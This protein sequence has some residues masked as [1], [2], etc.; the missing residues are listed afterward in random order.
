MIKPK[1]LITLCGL[2]LLASLLLNVVPE[3]QGLLQA[4]KTIVFNGTI[5]AQTT[6]LPWLH[7]SGQNIYDSNGNLVKIKAS[8]I[9][10]GDGSSVTETDIQNIKAMGFN[11]IRWWLYWGGQG[12][13][14]LPLQPTPSSINVNYFTVGQGE[15]S[16]T[17]TDNVITWAQNAG[18]YVILCP[19]WSET[20]PAPSW[21][22]MGSSQD[23]TPLFYNTQVQSGVYYMYNWIAQ[24]Y[25]SYSNVIFESMNEIQ[26]AQPV[27]SAD[28]TAFANFNAG[29]LSAIES[30][31]GANS[32]L[33]IIQMLLDWS[34][35]NYVLTGPFF[36]GTHANVLMATHSYAFVDTQM[37]SYL[38]YFAS[39]WANAIHAQNL[40]W[41]DTE[42]STAENTGGSPSQTVGLQQ[43]MDMFT[44]YNSAG[45]GYFCYN[46]FTNHQGD[47]NIANSAN[48]AQII[49]ILFSATATLDQ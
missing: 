40:P 28:R 33:K 18:L 44:K 26:K 36:S 24:R 7:T 15:P 19:G 30:G 16:G 6:G 12:G 5:S 13:T 29:W 3:S 42:F 23:A 17:S 43:A 2:I 14:N 27:S 22:G 9:S 46:S 8:V 1:R 11:A 49:P 39:Q 37:S 32:H 25:A 20:H 4:S 38:D 48:A 31:E 10:N 41:I 45:W 21:S 35:F 34:E 47:W